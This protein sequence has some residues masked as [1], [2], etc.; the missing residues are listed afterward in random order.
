[1]S[2]ERDWGTSGASEEGKEPLGVSENLLSLVAILVRFLI[3]NSHL[4]AHR[5]R[6]P[7]SLPVILASSLLNSYCCYGGSNCTVRKIESISA[8]SLVV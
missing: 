6:S 2:V 1:M 7:D 4:L 3:I 5:K 8:L